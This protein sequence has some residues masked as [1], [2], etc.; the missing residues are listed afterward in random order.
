MIRKR[1][2]E[3]SE[4]FFDQKIRGIFTSP[5]YLGLI[6]YHEQ[7][8]YA[9]ELFGFPRQD[10]LEIGALSKGQNRDAKENYINDIAAVLM[11]C[12]KYLQPNFDIFIVANDKN[13]LY[14]QIAE[15]S[16]LKIVNQ[17]KR[18]VL[19]RVE[20]DRS[21]YSETIFQMR[22]RMN[23]SMQ[24]RN[25]DVIKNSLRQKFSHY[26]PE[27]HEMPFH[28]RLL[29]RDRMA[30]FSFIHSLNTTFG[31]SIFE[32]VAIAISETRFQKVEGQFV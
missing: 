16:G 23:S 8:A 31:T 27:T 15:I 10:E 1:V 2:P 17:F 29:G 13:N 9:Y 28:Y 5:P 18:P 12:I 26:R 25:L 14:P 32:P 21:S 30:L 19:N 22:G 20:K 3:L 11:H 24:T 4:L 7:H 6:D